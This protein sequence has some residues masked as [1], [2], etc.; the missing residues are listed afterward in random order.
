MAISAFQFYLQYAHGKIRMH[1]IYN[2]I[3]ASIQIPTIIYVAYEYG[4]LGVALAWFLLRLVS[5]IVWTPIVHSKYAPG[6]HW[7]WLIRDVGPSFAMTSAILFVVIN[8]DFAIY[9]MS[10]WSIFAALFGIGLLILLCNILV[11]RA[12]RNLVFGTAH[13]YLASGS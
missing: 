12:P 4:A 5:F 8:I 11:S 9:D 10:R 1:V 13:K 3:A 2:T 6:L 7:P